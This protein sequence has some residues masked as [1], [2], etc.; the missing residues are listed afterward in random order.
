MSNNLF[1]KHNTNSKNI[2]KRKSIK[3]K[4]ST[5]RKSIKNI[6]KD[7]LKTMYPQTQMQELMKKQNRLQ[8]SIKMPFFQKSMLKC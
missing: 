2:Q 6:L 8:H 1:H 7:I 4:K 5:K 3:R